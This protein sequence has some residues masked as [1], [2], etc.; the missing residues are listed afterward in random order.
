[1]LCRSTFI[2][3][4]SLRLVKHEMVGLCGMLVGCGYELGTVLFMSKWYVL[5]EFLFQ[6][7]DLVQSVILGILKFMDVCATVYN[8]STASVPSCQN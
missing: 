6:H 1:M 7:V 5:G 3:Y 8:L 4:L 2:I